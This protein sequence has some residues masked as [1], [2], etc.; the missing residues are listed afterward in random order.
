MLEYEKTIVEKLQKS[1]KTQKIA[2][3]KNTH[4]PKQLDSS[5]TSS[6]NSINNKNNN[7]QKNYYT[8]RMYMNVRAL[9][10]I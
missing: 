3:E 10:N 5:S 1:G 7:N 6:T 2:R 9:C 4:K 8:D